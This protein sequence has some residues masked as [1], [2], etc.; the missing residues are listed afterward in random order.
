MMVFTIAITT[1]L[2]SYLWV[3]PAAYKLRRNHGRYHTCT[4]V[5]GGNGGMLVAVILTTFFTAVGSLEAVFPGLLWKL[6][7]QDYGSFYDSWGVG[8]T[9]FEVLGRRL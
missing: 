8:R 1:T 3:F 7:G 4:P 2:I 5:P 6:L 9:K